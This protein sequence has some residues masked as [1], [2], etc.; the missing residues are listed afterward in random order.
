MTETIL[1]KDTILVNIGDDHSFNCTATTLGRAGENNI[2]QL[3]ITIP[4]ELA[5]FDAYLDFKKQGGTTVRTPR[6][7]IENNKIEYDMPLS[8]LDQSGSIEVQLVLQDE[9]GYIW[10]SVAKKFTILK[11]V[12]A[13]DDIPEKEDFITE[14]QKILDEAQKILDDI[15]NAGGGGGGSLV[16]VSQVDLLSTDW[17][18]DNGLYAQIVNSPNA[19][20]NSKVDLNPTVEQLAVFHNKDL[21]FVTENDGGV[22]TVY[23]IGQ[24]PLNDYT[25]QV[26]L[27]EVVTNG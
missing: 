4:E 11:S 7:V 23:C 10:K 15:I 14:A 18:G 27:T 3:E 2:S 8:L 6:L 21:T 20:P 26:T 19:T 22:I 24:K 5:T 1:T 25:M 16:S 9:R 13:V 17:N 12:N